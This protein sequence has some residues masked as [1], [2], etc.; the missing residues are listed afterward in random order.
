MKIHAL[1]SLHAEPPPP[2]G[3]WQVVLRSLAGG[4][5]VKVSD[6]KTRTNTGR[7]LPPE[8]VRFAK[9]GTVTFGGI[10]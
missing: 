10:P 1:A 2:E 4:Q 7:S 9:T 3:V 8:A 5:E 6:I